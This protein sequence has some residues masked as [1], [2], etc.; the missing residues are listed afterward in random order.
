[1]SKP[2]RFLAGVFYLVATPAL[3][4]GQE[5]TDRAAVPA[6][7]QV[8]IHEIDPDLPPE[9]ARVRI[10]PFELS[11][12]EREALIRAPRNVL[13]AEPSDVLVRVL[14]QERLL[15]HARAERVTGKDI[16]VLQGYV[17]YLAGPGQYLHVLC[18]SQPA[19]PVVWIH[20]QE[21]GMGPP[22]RY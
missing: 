17:S 13:N 5:A 21:E 15:R 11:A 10:D 7:P 14:K 19:L 12:E 2:Q 3:T 22:E 1:M 8:L 4:W 20:C 16:D 18:V 6:T 9:Q